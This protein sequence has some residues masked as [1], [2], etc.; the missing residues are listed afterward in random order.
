MIRLPRN[1]DTSQEV[2]PESVTVL[3]ADEAERLIEILD[4]PPRPIAALSELLR[5]D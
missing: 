2:E 1:L 5:Q 3:S 4:A